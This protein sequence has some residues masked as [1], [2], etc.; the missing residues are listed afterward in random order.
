MKNIV[1]PL[2]ALLPLT[3]FAQ[4][5]FTIKGW[6]GAFKNGDRI[7]LVYKVDGETKADST[8]VAARQFEFK[9][10]IKDIAAG[11]ICRNDNPFTAAVLYDVTDI[12]IEPG[13]IAIAAKDSFKTA[14]ISGTQANEDYT[15]LKKS[16]R[17]L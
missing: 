17:Q 14:G 8:I 10:V 12:Y 6:G 16:L 11:Y 5:P 3:S 9:G 2:I 7:F 4:S 1:L 13:N 15:V